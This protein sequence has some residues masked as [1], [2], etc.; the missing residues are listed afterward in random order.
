VCQYCAIS[1]RGRIGAFCDAEGFSIHLAHRSNFN[2][3]RSAIRFSYTTTLAISGI[4]EI[5]QESGNCRGDGENSVVFDGHFIP[6]ISIKGIPN[7]PIFQPAAK[8]GK[9]VECSGKKYLL[10]DQWMAKNQLQPRPKFFRNIIKAVL[11]FSLKNLSDFR[12]I[13]AER[14]PAHGPLIVV[15]NHFSWLDPI[16]VIAAFSWHPEFMG[17][18]Q[19][20]SAPFVVR[21]LP[22]LWGYFNVHRGYSS[23]DALNSAQ[24]VLDQGGVL[25]IFPEAGAWAA[26][27]RPPRPGAA[28]LAMRTG[29][30]LLPIGL[31]GFNEVFPSIRNGK[32]ARVTITVG[33]VFGPFQGDVRGRADRERMDEVGHTMMRKI[34]ELIPKEKRGFYSDDPN[35]REAAKGTEIFPWDVK[36]EHDW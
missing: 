27:L 3:S 33:E 15:G 19:M 23:R 16:A 14:V 6:P 2:F 21:S 29:A 13:G 31:D 1:K 25:S 11:G 10:K 28:L 34:A 32:R 20:P 24:K 4:N 7:D 5:F 18:T 17:G 22:K 8:D 12:V 26:T 35:V 9:V 36:Q 30:P